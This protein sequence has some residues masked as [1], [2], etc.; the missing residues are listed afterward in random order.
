[1]LSIV[2]IEEYFDR[3]NECCSHYNINQ[4]YLVGSFASGKNT[5]KSDIDFLISFNG[6][7]KP[8]SDK[9]LRF[10]TPRTLEVCQNILYYRRYF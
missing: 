7:I 10:V 1:M 3:L 4:L 9:L 2:K 8:Y 5:S 6:L